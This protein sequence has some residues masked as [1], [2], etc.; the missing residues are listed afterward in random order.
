MKGLKAKNAPPPAGPVKAAKPFVAPKPKAAKAAPAKKTT[1]SKASKSG[2]AP[3]SAG[4]TL[5]KSVPKATQGAV[6][7]PIAVPPPQPVVSASKKAGAAAP[8]APT[9]VKRGLNP[10][11][12]KR[13]AADAS[14]LSLFAGA[15]AAVSKAT[16]DAP[17]VSGP[18]LS[19]AGDTVEAVGVVLAEVVGVAVA[20]SLVGGL[21]S[22]GK[23][24][25]AA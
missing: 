6:S 24:R 22:G 4:V 18:G 2:F 11:A 16:A 3:S 25:A 13:K 10:V 19:V 17:R 9:S 1:P 15:G 7:A 23:K 14:V 21:T 5:G 20:S 12:P 8:A